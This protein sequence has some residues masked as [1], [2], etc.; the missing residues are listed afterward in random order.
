[1]CVLNE[2]GATSNSSN[3][4]IFHPAELD[5]LNAVQ[6]ADAQVIFLISNVN[7]RGRDVEFTVFAEKCD[8]FLLQKMSAYRIHGYR[9]GSQEEPPVRPDIAT[10]KKTGPSSI[11]LGL[12]CAKDVQAGFPLYDWQIPN[13][14][15]IRAGIGMVFRGPGDE[16][17]I[18][19][20]TA[21]NP[22][23]VVR[24]YRPHIDESCGV[25]EYWVVP[26]TSVIDTYI[27]F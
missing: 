16:L 18:I 7:V 2:S 14:G 11:K 20:Y 9:I 19:F 4:H 26:D 6:I 23:P 12:E 21:P 22:G 8:S 25:L 3:Q 15:Q 10:V 17:D 1:M 24:P 13:L 5:Q 27:F